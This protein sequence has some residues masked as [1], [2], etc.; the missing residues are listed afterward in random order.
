MV[1]GFAAVGRD[2]FSSN[3]SPNQQGMRSKGQFSDGMCV[4]T[5]VL[6]AGKAH[7]GEGTRL[8]KTAV[9]S[10]R[11]ANQITSLHSIESFQWLPRALCAL[12]GSPWPPSPLPAINPL[13]APLNSSKMFPSPSS[14]QGLCTCCTSLQECSSCPSRRYQPSS[15]T[16]QSLDMNIH[17]RQGPSLPTLTEI[18]PATPLFSVLPF[19][20]AS[21]RPLTIFILICLPVYCLSLPPVEKVQEVRDH[22]SLPPLSP[23]MNT[24]G[25][26]RRCQLLFLLFYYCRGV[27]SCYYRLAINTA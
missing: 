14:P 5:G 26:L 12:E 20:L 18:I 19:C 16:S 11:I 4:G 2:V 10:F 6:G 24:R 27:N 7:R 3:L 17:T 8:R 13:V 25:A 15:H 21:C 9:G 1:R 23:A 22:L